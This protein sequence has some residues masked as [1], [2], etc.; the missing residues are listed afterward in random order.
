MEDN[1]LS[2]AVD[3]I[4]KGA[5]IP[6]VEASLL[7]HMW[8]AL[9][10]IPRE[11]RRTTG[12]DLGAVARVELQNPDQHVAI[13]A[14]YALMDAI[15]E[16]GALD[17]YIKDEPLRVFAAAASLPCRK[18]DLA[19]AL[20]QRLLREA[21]PEVAEKAIAEMKEAGCDPDHPN[22]CNKFIEWMRNNC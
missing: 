16:R 12:I 21:S 3:R 11:Q 15:I 6:T 19:E 2:A 4:N 10:S 17:E 22:V 14:R 9:S 13:M 18:D 20:A 8:E 7:K 1:D 5:E